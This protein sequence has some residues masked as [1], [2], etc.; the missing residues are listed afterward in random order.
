MLEFF[1]NFNMVKPIS[2]SLHF[3]GLFQNTSVRRVS[4]FPRALA[5][6][7]LRDFN[8]IKL[9][10]DGSSLGNPSSIGGGGIA[11][12][13]SGSVILSFTE[14]FGCCTKLQAEAHALLHGIKFYLCHSITQATIE[15]DSKVLL[16][17]VQNK[18]STPWQLD[19]LIQHIQHPLSEGQLCCN[20]FT[21][22][23]TR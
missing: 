8:G 2:S 1:S 10:V 20:M 23:Q 11:Q 18:S 17:I 6:A 21:K 19:G 9:N 16:D 12:D 22:K 15:M 5:V 7:W 3:R 14:F 4:K 13:N